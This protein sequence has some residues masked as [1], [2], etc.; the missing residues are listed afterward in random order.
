MISRRAFGPGLCATI[1]LGATAILGA[2]G[3][4]TG[5]D[6][7]E[8][9]VGGYLDRVTA[10]AT[11]DGF[12]AAGRDLTGTLAAGA[13]E[14]TE[15]RMEAGRE[16]ML[17]GACDNDCSDMDLEIYD[18]A[19]HEIDSDLEYDDVPVVMVT[20]ERT[21]SYRLVIGMAGCSRE[22]CYYGTRI[23]HR[24]AVAPSEH[25]QLVRAQLEAFSAEM[26]KQG[27]QRTHGFRVDTLDPGGSREFLV[28]LK[29]G[30]TYGIAGFCDR[31]CADLDLAI[32]AGEAEPIAQ[33][34]EADDH[35]A[36]DLAVTGTGVFRIRVTMARCATATCVYG[37]ALHGRPTRD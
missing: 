23:L 31:D 33:D 35:P 22:P 28:R 5:Q 1:G 30:T 37:V 9:R 14:G 18:P 17:V 25:H 11:E 19:G 7:R 15:I 8:A 10:P 3:P 4:A 36:L 2:P 32:F 27:Y 13:S 21:A 34:V 20:P 16:Y 6:D 29:E 12:T 24:P 26:R